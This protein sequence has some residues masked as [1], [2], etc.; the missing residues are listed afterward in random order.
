MTKPI[1]AIGDIH[2]Q[3]DLLDDMLARIEADGGP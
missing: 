3:I 1:Y 2:G